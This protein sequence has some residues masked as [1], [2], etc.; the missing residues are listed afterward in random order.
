MLIVVTGKDTSEAKAKKVTV[1][2]VNLEGMIKIIDDHNLTEFVSDSD[3]TFVDQTE[4]N[5]VYKLI[6]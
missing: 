2:S 4:K 3:N 1:L 5:I 6:T